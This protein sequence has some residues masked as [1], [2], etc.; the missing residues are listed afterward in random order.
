VESESAILD[1]NASDPAEKLLT[2]K[3]LIGSL[4]DAM[5]TFYLLQELAPE[6]HAE[7]YRKQQY[8]NNAI[9][10]RIEEIKTA[11][12][13]NDND[14]DFDYTRYDC[15]DLPKGS[16]RFF[17]R[18]IPQEF[19]INHKLRAHLSSVSEILFCHGELNNSLYFVTAT[20]GEEIGDRW[21]RKFEFFKIVCP[22]DDKHSPVLL[23]I[24]KVN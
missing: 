6:V 24:R 19:Y 15:E 5:R 2:E 22:P 21:E 11:S 1:I 12:A 16:K 18:T 4:T 13:D 20:R 9:L 8:E 7:V 17:K 23:W 3:E 10:R 14:D